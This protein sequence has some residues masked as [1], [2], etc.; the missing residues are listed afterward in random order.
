MRLAYG[1]QRNQAVRN[2]LF[3]KLVVLAEVAIIALVSCRNKQEYDGA[4]PTVTE[5]SEL[6]VDKIR[7]CRNFEDI[8][9][10]LFDFAS[11]LAGKKD[12]ALFYE[13]YETI[14]ANMLA[15]MKRS[16]DDNLPYVDDLR[17]LAREFNLRKTD[18]EKMAIVFLALPRLFERDLIIPIERPLGITIEQLRV[19]AEKDFLKMVEGYN[20]E[21]AKL[22]RKYWYKKDK[23]TPTQEEQ[24]KF[25]Q[26]LAGLY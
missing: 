25:F 10:E 14:D 8:K 21:L 11:Y 15:L 13:A 12:G 26:D 7:A 3:P 9:K 1:T 6:I 17:I 4:M 24:R 2:R 19:D 18:G 20:P 16:K 23:L 5:K 22:M